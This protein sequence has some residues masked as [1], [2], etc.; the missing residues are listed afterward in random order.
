M[1]LDKS[2]KLLIT[3]NECL[4]MSYCIRSRLE[5]TG[6]PNQWLKVFI[7]SHLLII[8]WHA[9]SCS[10]IDMVHDSDLQSLL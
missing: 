2:L 4:C 3:N 5:G 1:S 6:T 7:N 8:M 10:C 9:Q